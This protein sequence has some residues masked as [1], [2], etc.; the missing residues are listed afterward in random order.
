MGLS[1]TFEYL[2]LSILSTPHSLL[3][4]G[5]KNWQERAS[6]CC[7]AK[8]GVYKIVSYVYLVSLTLSY[9][10]CIVRPR[11]SSGGMLEALN[12]K[13]GFALSANLSSIFLRE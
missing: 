9:L 3:E 10:G 5:M 13:S 1:I 7:C 11:L 6:Y 8:Y 12:L 2:G 4:K